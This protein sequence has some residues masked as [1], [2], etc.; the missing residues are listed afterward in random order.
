MATKV[1]TYMERRIFACEQYRMGR[2]S[3]SGWHVETF[4]EPTNMPY[5]EQHTPWFAT[6]GEAKAAIKIEA[7]RQPIECVD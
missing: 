2:C 3:G 5:G 7:E 6:I 1:H 4:H